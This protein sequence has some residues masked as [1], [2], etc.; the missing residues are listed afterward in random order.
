MGN[1]TPHR[2]TSRWMNLKYAGT[3]KVCGTR[4]P[5]GAT[6]FYDAD[7]RTV[8]CSQLDCASADGLTV[9]RAPTGPWEGPPGTRITERA[10]TR[11]V[12]TTFNSGESVYVNSRGRCEDAPC[13]G[14]C[15]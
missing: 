3:C 11:S 12:V 8:T 6:A 13:C 4:V 2:R 15:S 7:A 14:C 9:D 5:Q 10:P 1:R